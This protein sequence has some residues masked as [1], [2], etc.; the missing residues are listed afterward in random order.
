VHGGE[1]FRFSLEYERTPKTFG[2]YG[3]I[4]N[5][6]EDETLL[7]TILYLASNYHLMCIVRDRV[8]P[9]RVRVCVGLVREFMNNLLRT[10]VMIAGTN[11]REV[12]L[13]NIW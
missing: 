6:L 9:Q 5:A 10:P 1:A 12:P 13:Q 7:D 2:A 11:Q 8:T 4:A 3:E